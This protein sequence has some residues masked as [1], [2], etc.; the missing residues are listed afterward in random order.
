MKDKNLGISVEKLI[1]RKKKLQDE[2][3]STIFP[4]LGTK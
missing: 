3:K 2:A 1:Y 4:T